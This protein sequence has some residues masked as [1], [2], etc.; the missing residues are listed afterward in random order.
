VALLVGT[1]FVTEVTG[2]TH[3][4]ET[5]IRIITPNGVLVVEVDDPAVKVTIEEDGGLVFT[6]AGPQEIRL[7]AGDYR[8]RA[9]KDGQAFAVD[10][11]LVTVERGGKQIVRVIRKAPK[12]ISRPEQLE[13]IEQAFAEADKQF[14]SGQSLRDTDP[15]KAEVH[16]R[17]AIALSEP[18]L[19]DIR[20]KP[21]WEQKLAGY[22]W[23]LASS[24]NMQVVRVV[25]HNADMSPEEAARAIAASEEAVELLP[26]AGF[27]TTLG[28][29]HYRAK[30]WRDASKALE[31]AP[32]GPGY[33]PCQA[34]FARAL[35]HWRLGDH[36]KARHSFENAARWMD[37]NQP[38]DPV[39][40]RI[41]AEAKA[42]LDEK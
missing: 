23:W 30:N 18:W 7:P 12:N 20:G 37:Q 38:T 14:A 29:A 8:V 34:E 42:L 3:F 36:E 40:Q 17:K 39:L 4:A 35:V 15:S 1:L 26:D 27:Y 5:I 31:K 28:L 19:Q 11:P 24:L 25:Y 16:L 33:N 2:V 10:Q 22:R 41:R 9:S 21:Q 6:G 32:W 13:R